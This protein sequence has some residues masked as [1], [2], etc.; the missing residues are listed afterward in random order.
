MNLYHY[1]SQEAF[2]SIL[3]TRTFRCSAL[4]LS[5]DTMEGKWIHKIFSDICDE[6]GLKEQDKNLAIMLLS[7]VNEFYEGFGFCLSALGDS[8]SQWRGY[9]Q[10]GEGLCIG[11]SKDGLEALREKIGKS[12]F[13]LIQVNY[14]LNQQQ[15]ELKPT[16]KKIKKF[17]T[18]LHSED[19]EEG[20]KNITKQLVSMTKEIL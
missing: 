3:R 1:C 10:D 6:D 12:N 11:F 17:I 14:D 18:E 9:A 13:D 8:L 19:T 4:S 5:N 2:L 20:R 7:I 15:K 16:Y